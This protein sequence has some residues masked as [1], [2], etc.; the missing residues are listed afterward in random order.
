MDENNKNVNE[1][2]FAESVDPEAAKARQEENAQ[3]DPFGQEQS[4]QDR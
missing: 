3:K 1:E 2:I 4:G